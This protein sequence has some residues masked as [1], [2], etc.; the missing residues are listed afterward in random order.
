[1]NIGNGDVYKSGGVAGGGGFLVYKNLLNT[2]A[3]NSCANCITWV[4]LV[5][6]AGGSTAPSDPPGGINMAMIDA[7]GNATV[8]SG[9]NNATVDLFPAYGL[10]AGN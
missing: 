8:L 3:S 9:I 10:P 5:N 4:A 7:L 1:M 6:T 2:Y